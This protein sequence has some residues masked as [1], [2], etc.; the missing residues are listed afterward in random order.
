MLFMKKNLK[1]I[2]E[3]ENGEIIEGIFFFVEFG[4]IIFLLEDGEIV[5]RDLYIG[6]RDDIFIFI[7]INNGCSIVYKM[8]V[9]CGGR[10]KVCV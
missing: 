10:V 9:I 7:E 4:V 3:W 8:I 6:W 5:L 1:M 2:L